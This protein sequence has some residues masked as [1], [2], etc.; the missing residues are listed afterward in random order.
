[1]IDR[2]GGGGGSYFPVFHYIEQELRASFACK[3]EVFLTWEVL[4]PYD[5]RS[6]VAPPPEANGTKLIN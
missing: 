1:V 2:T 5:P 6:L 4:D 3:L